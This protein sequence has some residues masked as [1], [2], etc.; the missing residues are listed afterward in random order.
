MS[1]KRAVTGT[2]HAPTAFASSAPSS[3]LTD[4]EMSSR[5]AKGGRQQHLRAVL[6]GGKTCTPS[7]PSEGRE[8]EKALQQSGECKKFGHEW[9]IFWVA[10]G[11]QREERTMW[12]RSKGGERERK[13]AQRENKNR[14]FRGGLKRHDGGKAPANLSFQAK[15]T[16]LGGQYWV[17]ASEGSAT[18]KWSAAVKA[19]S[20]NFQAVSTELRM[21]GCKDISTLHRW[22]QRKQVASGAGVQVEGLDTTQKTMQA[23]RNQCN[24]R[25]HRCGALRAQAAGDAEH[26]RENQCLSSTPISQPQQPARSRLPQRAPTPP[27]GSK[28]S[29]TALRPSNDCRHAW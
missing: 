3:A 12:M 20:T 2:G 6:R 27:R 8:Q 10:S 7:Q 24:Q 29:W 19:T 23:C 9:K 1:D 25:Y 5:A 22:M 14:G 16:V 13:P 11:Q 21:C 18:D 26:T 4:S 17:A 15:R 28:V